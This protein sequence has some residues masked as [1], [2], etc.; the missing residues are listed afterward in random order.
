MPKLNWVLAGI[1]DI[2]RRR[3]IPAIQTEPRSTMYGFVT[4]NAAKAAAYAGARAFTT[5]EEAVADPQVDA[6]YIA[7][8]VAMHADA[9]IAALRG[10]RVYVAEEDIGSGYYFPILGDGDLYAAENG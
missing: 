5:V 4:R 2:A 3:V 9:A 10:G 8:P 1:G 7:L 6:L